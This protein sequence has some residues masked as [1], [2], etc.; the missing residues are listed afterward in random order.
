MKLLNSEK[1]V[2]GYDLCD[3]YCQI[4]YCTSES[5]NVETIS[6]VAGAEVFN[7]P[8]V[9]CKREGV[10]QWF[11]GKEAIR[12][13]QEGQGILVERLLSLALDGEPIQIEGNSFQPAALLT[14]FIKRSLGMLSQIASV[15]KISAIMITCERMNHES[16][17][18]LNQVVSNLGLKTDKIYFQSH[19]ESFYHYMIQQ[20]EELWRFQTFLCEYR[21][22]H[23]R[24]YRM[25][26]NKY[27][28]P[29]VAFID[30]AE[31]PFI[32]YEPMPENESMRLD[33]QRRMDEEFLELVKRVYEN[34]LISSIYLIGEH[35]SEEWM[36]ESLKYLCKGRRVFQGNNLYSK[37]ACYGMLERLQESEVGRNHVF[38]GN[39]KLKS[40]I[41]MKILRRGQESYFALLDAGGNW[42]EA[43]ADLE[44]YLYEENYVE[45]IITSLVGKNS[46]IARIVIEDL[47]EG[48]SRLRMHLYLKDEQHLTVTIE[49]LGFGAFREATHRVWEE[50]IEL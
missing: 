14:L 3:D 28:N 26:C 18:V 2:V 43:E 24:M 12:Y 6:S 48:I 5:D 30:E 36:K 20:P 25:E 1:V 31:Y 11:Y 10:N 17:E 37:G 40:N 9:L 16:L 7:I 4:S 44:F 15:D 27:T 45:L 46:K 41:G 8:T 47:P 50:E 23:V 13:A 19:K 38:L 32:S 42:F 22:N 35:Y 21:D 29:V 49:D 39:E 33:K 34:Q